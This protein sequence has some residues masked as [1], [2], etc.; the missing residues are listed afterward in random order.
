[1]AFKLYQNKSSLNNKNCRMVRG[2]TTEISGQFLGYWDKATFPTDNITDVKFTI[3]SDYAFRA[4]KISY[5]LYGRDDFQ[6]LVLQYNNIVDI[7][8]ELTVGSVL[9]LPSYARTLYN[10]TSD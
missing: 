8:E 2:G 4:D 1:M 6:W 3:T 9:I 10:L 5:K 7:N